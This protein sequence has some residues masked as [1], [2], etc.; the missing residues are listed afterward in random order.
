MD[1]MDASALWATASVAFGGAATV[2]AVQTAQPE[3][4]VVTPNWMEALLWASP[5]VGA[6]LVAVAKASRRGGNYESMFDENRRDIQKNSQA[7][8]VLSKEVRDGLSRNSEA[9]A[10]IEGALGAKKDGG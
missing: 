3:Q 6:A 2:V 8:E 9:L 7:I 4:I 5:F 1:R 10:R